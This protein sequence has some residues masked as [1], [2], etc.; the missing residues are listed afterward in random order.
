MSSPRQRNPHLAAALARKGMTFRDLA[1]VADLHPVTL[2]RVHNGRQQLSSATAERVA[3]VLDST[4][5]DLGLV[6]GR[7]A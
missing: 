2:S 7:N 1:A 6:S 5:A 3:H 4:P